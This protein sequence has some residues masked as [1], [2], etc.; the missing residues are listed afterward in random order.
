LALAFE[1]KEPRAEAG[2]REL[3]ADAEARLHAL[4][5]RQSAASPT[6]KCFDAGKARAGLARSLDRNIEIDQRFSSTNRMK[7]LSVAECMRNG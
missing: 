1:V 4:E 7:S 3:I 6:R 5:A 2:L